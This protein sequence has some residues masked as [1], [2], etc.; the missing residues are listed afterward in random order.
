MERVTK[1]V[2]GYIAVL[3]DKVTDVFDEYQIAKARLCDLEDKIENGELIPATQSEDKLKEALNIEK[4]KNELKTKEIKLLKQVHENELKARVSLF[5]KLIC[6][7]FDETT[8]G[9]RDER[10]RTE[11]EFVEIVKRIEEFLNG[12]GSSE[13]G[14]KEV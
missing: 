4:A 9:T 13:T 5:A 14:E 10:Q 2:A 6:N 3:S 8:F 1:R 7:E 12:N 11:S